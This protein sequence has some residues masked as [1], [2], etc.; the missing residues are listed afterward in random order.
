MWYRYENLDCQQASFYFFLPFL[1]T[2]KR[3]DLVRLIDPHLISTVYFQTGKSEKEIKVY[4]PGTEKFHLY[5]YNL[6]QQVLFTYPLHIY[7][8]HCHV[9]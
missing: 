2:Y 9:P 5:I 8:K 4:K 3:I 1:T 6:G 7:C